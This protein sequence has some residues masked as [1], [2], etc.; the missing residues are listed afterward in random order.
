[1]SDLKI[2]RWAFI[3]CSFGAEAGQKPVVINGDGISAVWVGSLFK[4][5]N[6]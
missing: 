6:S 4:D 2:V 5:K 3:L 1:M